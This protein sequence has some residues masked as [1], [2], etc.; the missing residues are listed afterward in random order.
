MELT[1]SYAARVPPE[2]EPPAPVRYYQHPRAPAHLLAGITSIKNQ[3]ETDMSSKRY[4]G[5]SPKRS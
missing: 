3:V 2:D 1:N 4:P 5:I